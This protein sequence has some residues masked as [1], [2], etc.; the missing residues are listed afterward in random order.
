TLFAVTTAFG[1]AMVPAPGKSWSLETIG[2]GGLILWP[3]F[4]ATNQLLAGLS[5][6]V[7]SFYLRRR[8]LPTWIAGLPMVFMLAIPAWA[9][10][11]NIDAWLSGGSF[12]LVTIATVMLAVELWLIIEGVLLWGRIRGILEPPAEP[13]S[14]AS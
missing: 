11:Y 10:I 1:L 7:V 6:L 9:L 2:T 12:G 3:L 5:L 13:S 14:P 8:Q 4:G